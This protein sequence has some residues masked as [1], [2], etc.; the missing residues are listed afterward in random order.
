VFFEWER[1]FGSQ[2]GAALEDFRSLFAALDYKVEVLEET[3]PG[4]QADYPA[5]PR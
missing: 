5:R 2:H 4:R 3:S 1:D